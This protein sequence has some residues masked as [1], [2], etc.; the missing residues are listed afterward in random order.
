MGY[1]FISLAK[2]PTI[3]ALD[4]SEWGL[5]VFGLILTIGALGEYKRLPGLALRF[6]SHTTFELMVAVGIAGEFLADGGVFLFS[7]HLQAI[8]DG[9]FAGLNRE[10]ADARR[11][12]ASA[13]KESGKA[14]KDAGDAIERASTNEKEA[15][16]LRKQAA[17]LMVDVANANAMAEDARSMAKG[18]Q[19]QIAGFDAQAK[20]A[21]ADAAKANLE[22]AKL[23]TPRSLSRQQ[24]EAIRSTA[25]LFK[26]TPYDLWVNLDSDSTNIMNLLDETLRSA[27]WVFTP[28]TIPIN[29]SGKAA[30]TSLSGVIIEIAEEKRPEFERVASLMRSALIAQG[31]PT[32]AHANSSDPD[33]NKSVVHIMIGSKPTN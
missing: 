21:I 33:K 6:F 1:F 3:T 26:G 16:S 18:F 28:P 7:R 9:E 25:A 14:R 30:I 32:V 2:S 19:S 13:N 5:L 22:L 4:V 15:A 24:L 10:A 31:I 20:I 11:E 29:F 8:S 17:A 23:K 27:G 12:A